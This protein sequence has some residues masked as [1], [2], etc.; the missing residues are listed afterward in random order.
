MRH[1]GMLMAG[2]L[3]LAVAAAAGAEEKAPADE[4]V[5]TTIEAL[6]ARNRDL[7]KRLTDLEGKIGEGAEAQRVRREEVRMM[8]D[9]AMLDSKDK[10]APG[11][12]ENLKFGGDFR[13]RYEAAHQTSRSVDERARF[14][15]RFGFTK[16]WPKEDLEVGFRLASG[17]NN[18]PTSTNQTFEDMFQ[19][20]SIWID[21]AYAKWTPKAVKGLSLTAGKFANPFQSSD[22]IWDSD[23]VPEGAWLEYRYPGF[24]DAF[25][26]FVG[27]GIF[28]LGFD[29]AGVNGMPEGRSPVLDAYTAGAVVKVAKDVTWTP[30]LTFYN[31]NQIEQQFMRTPFAA[32]GNTVRNVGGNKLVTDEMEQF[33]IMNKV[34]FKAFNLPMSVYGD[35]VKNCGVNNRY[36]LPNGNTPR[37][38]DEAWA[39]GLAV[40]E[41]KKKGDWMFAYKYAYIQSDAVLGYFAD[42]DFGYGNRKGSVFSLVY[43]VTDYMTAGFSLFYTSPIWAPARVVGQP[44]HESQFTG[45]FDLVWKF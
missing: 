24:G 45:L 18:D 5:K 1:R 31:F 9:K 12:L 23:V 14:R 8:I 21:R 19:K 36:G 4:D 6:K 33:E 17:N 28:E 43:N 22:I 35:W 25:T 34:S 41:N 27:A 40:G 39:L 7:E 15:L 42:S 38:R 32:R 13:L 16:T 29:A 20:Q 26:P 11:W 3:L 30:S 2:V 37:E 10:F 44:T